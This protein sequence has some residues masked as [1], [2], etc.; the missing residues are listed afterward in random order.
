MLDDRNISL[1]IYDDKT[2]EEIFQRIK[3][4]Y[5]IQIEKII[6]TIEEKVNCQ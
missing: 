5:L 4:V 2:S 3:N 1:H 6:K